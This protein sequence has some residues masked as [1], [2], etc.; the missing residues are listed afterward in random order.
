MSVRRLLMQNSS[1]MFSGDS[2][3]SSPISMPAG[4]E[5]RLADESSLAVRGADLYL[6]S[7]LRIEERELRLR[8][9]AQL[10]PWRAERQASMRST[11]SA[12]DSAGSKGAAQ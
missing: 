7:S 9:E 2:T 4:K 3:R 11:H 1:W 8:G 10:A 12:R 6:A 5:A